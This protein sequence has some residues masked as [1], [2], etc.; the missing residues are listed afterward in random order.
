L[1]HFTNPTAI[2]APLPANPGGRG[3]SMRRPC[4]G[5]CRVFQHTAESAHGV[6]RSGKAAAI[7]SWA[8][9]F[10][11]PP[12]VIDRRKRAPQLA[13]R[14][15]HNRPRPTVFAGVALFRP[16]VNFWQSCI[17][18]VRLYKNGGNV[19]H[20]NSFKPTPLRGAA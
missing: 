1:P 12:L 15:G 2:D 9:V 18:S 20:N 7:I 17:A 11:T 6:K 4:S 16:S 10:S 8:V 5:F 3:K 13:R 19:S 14:V